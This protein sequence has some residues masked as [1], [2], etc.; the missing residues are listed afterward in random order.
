[1]P[2]DAAYA[3][4]ADIT[5]MGEWSPENRGGHWLGGASVAAAGARFRG[6][7][8]HGPFR[9]ST[10]CTIV[11][12]VP[13]REISWKVHSTFGLPVS[14]WR[15]TFM[16]DG[17]GGTVV[18]E[19]TEDRRGWL[20]RTVSPFATGVGDRADRNRQTM[21]ATLAALKRILEASI[22]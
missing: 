1:M 12:A 11:T 3:A 8:R 20:I 14:L 16:D 21:A 2:P 17:S 19:S 18:T 13:G 4:V 5:R 9:W 7:N 6:K 10:T 22:A 15:Y